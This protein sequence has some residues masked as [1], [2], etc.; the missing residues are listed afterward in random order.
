MK[1]LLGGCCVIE[2]WNRMVNFLPL[3]ILVFIL[4]LTLVAALTLLNPINAY[5]KWEKYGNRKQ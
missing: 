2:L 4:F 5:L 1:P 3:S